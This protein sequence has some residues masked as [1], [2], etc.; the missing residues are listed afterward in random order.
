MTVSILGCGW[1]GRA[2]AKALLENNIIVKGS[3]TSSEK[4]EQLRASGIE[5]YLVQFS[6]GTKSYEPEFFKCDILVVSITPKMRQGESGDYLSKIQ[7]IVNAITEYK[8][9]RVIYISSTTVYGDYKREV[10]EMDE[11]GPDATTGT[12]L[13]AAEDT[14]RTQTAFKTTVLRFSGLV[15]PGRHPGR[16]FAGKKDIPNGRAPVNLIHLDDCTGITLA[17]IERDFFG[18]VLNACAPDHPLKQDFYKTAALHAGLVAPEF[19]NELHGWKIIKSTLMPGVL[20][21]NF[22]VPSWETFLATG[23]L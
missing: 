13:L 9:A 22:K 11:P 3:T 10:T 7:N 19:I 23:Q 18:H 17:I 2:L 20:K 16:F 15:G 21:Y 14:F 4:L 12:I 8:V 5:P 6:T 1:Y